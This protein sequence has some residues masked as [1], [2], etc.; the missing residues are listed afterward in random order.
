ME[1]EAE[2]VAR[3]QG[4]ANPMGQGKCACMLS[5]SVTSDSFRLH[6]L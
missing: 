4:I 6:G 2:E 3:G 1:G 5:C